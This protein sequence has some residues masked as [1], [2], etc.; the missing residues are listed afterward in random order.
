MFEKIK[1]F[2][3]SL[4]KK[5]WEWIKKEVKNLA[6]MALEMF[7]DIIY[8]L[9]VKIIEGL[10]KILLGIEKISTGEYE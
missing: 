9:I 1:S 6:Q 3:V 7:L 5:V 4:P 10:E 2:F 8:Q